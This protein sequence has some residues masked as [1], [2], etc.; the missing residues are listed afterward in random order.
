[1]IM[2]ATADEDPAGWLRKAGEPGRAEFRAA[3]AAATAGTAV[4]VLQW[5]A[6]AFAIAMTLRTGPCAGCLATA[7]AV[8]IGTGAAR[9]AALHRSRV[10]ARRGHGAIAFELRRKLVAAVLPHRCD[11]QAA[12]G[13]QAG[14]TLIEL[15][16]QV[17]AYHERTAPVSRAAGPSSALVLAVIALL[18]WP[19]AVMLAL[20]TPLIPVNMRLAGQATRDASKRKLAEFRRLSEQ[21]LDRF[22]GMGT[23]VT[24]G[25]VERETQVVQQAC[26]ALNRAT[27]AVL[28]RAFMVSSVLEAV[29]TCSI[30]VCATYVGLVLLGY[31]HLDGTPRLGLFAG[32]LVLLLC[33]VYFAPLREHAAGYH[34][35]DEALASAGT[36]AGLSAA[37]A[38]LAPPREP[39]AP[40]WPATAPAIDIDRVTVR[41]EGSGAPV[42]SQISAF[43]PAGSFAVLAAPSGAGKTTLLRLL[44]GL[45]TPE[46]GTIRL[47][48]DGTTLGWF[49]YPGYASRIGQRTVLLAGSLARNVSLGKPGASRAEIEL[50]A[51]RAGLAGLIARLPD[52]LD[53]EVGERGWGISAGEA[54]RVALARALLRDAPLWLLDEPTAHLDSG[55]E[56]ELVEEIRSAAAGRTVLIASHSAAVIASADVLWRLDR[57]DLLVTE[58]FR[59]VGMTPR[60]PPLA[61]AGAV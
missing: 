41:F 50:A 29:I 43:L 47:V 52:G 33:P 58:R 39:I 60:N 30:A 5:A 51:S 42:L 24:L 10:R 36:L 45:I 27:S 31:L 56:Q 25:A 6:V 53:T 49:P 32:T 4:T 7:S 34:E 19:V 23:L 20:A 37:Q 26:D 61:T 8:V 40:P 48:G 57:G 28:R 18:H 16:D 35:R 1:M 38:G 55:T 12:D 54:R 59:L 9:A 46:A 21:L 17:A 22:R 2:T 3:A 44:A 11:G 15:V 13:A 14:H